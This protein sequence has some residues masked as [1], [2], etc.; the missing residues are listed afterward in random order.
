MDRE[1]VISKIDKVQ[2]KGRTMVEL[3]NDVHYKVSE[4]A[5]RTNRSI[6]EIA[7]I[8]IR[9]SLKYVKIDELKKDNNQ[10]RCDSCQNNTDELSGECYEC[11]KGIEDWYE[12]ISKLKGENEKC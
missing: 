10:S 8:L 12:P 5:F 1:I 11:V 2:K 6:R 4:I 7:S 9:D 3:D